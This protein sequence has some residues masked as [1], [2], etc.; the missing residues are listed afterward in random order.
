MIRFFA[1]LRMTSEEPGMKREKII[2]IGEGLRMTSEGLRM[3]RWGY[4]LAGCS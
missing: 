4:P 2:M 1:A 3:T